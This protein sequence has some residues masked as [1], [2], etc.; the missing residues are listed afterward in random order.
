[1]YLA[2]TYYE[3][4]HSDFDL[5]SRSS[6]DPRGPTGVL[7]KFKVRQ[8][9]DARRKKKEKTTR[10]DGNETESSQRRSKSTVM[11]MMKQLDDPE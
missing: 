11:M 5:K 2:V 9:C 8:W 7:T 10:K 4:E 6:G 1:M 3:Y